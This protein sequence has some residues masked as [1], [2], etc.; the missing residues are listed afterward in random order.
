[1][2]IITGN[3][4]DI[5]EGII[6]HQVNSRGVAGVGLAQQ[7]RDR[8]PDWFTEYRRFTPTLS[9]LGGVH[10]YE[11]TSLQNR[12]QLSIASLLA[13]DGYGR[14]KRYTNYAYLATAL[15]NVEAQ[16]TG[17]QVYIPYKLGCGNG[18]GDWNIV[19]QII[20][21]AIPDVIIVKLP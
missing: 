15:L 6:C 12:A 16:R 19:Q 8:W 5:T 20:A 11:V 21:D 1:M 18:G 3:I 14:D 13:Q 4:L 9:R 7:I 10:W 17:E 2:N